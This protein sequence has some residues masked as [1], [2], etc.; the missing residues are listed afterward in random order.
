MNMPSLSPRSNLIV[1]VAGYYALAV[2][3]VVIVTLVLDQT[4]G[5]HHGTKKSIYKICFASAALVFLIAWDMAPVAKPDRKIMLV[6]LLW[7]Y[8]GWILFFVYYFVFYG[9]FGLGRTGSLVGD[10]LIVGLFGFAGFLWQSVSSPF[11]RH[12]ALGRCVDGQRMSRADSHVSFPFSSLE[13]NECE[14]HISPTTYYGFVSVAAVIVVIVA[15]A[16]VGEFLDTTF[17]APGYSGAIAAALVV[18][19]IMYPIHSRVSRFISF[20]MQ[21]DVKEARRN[22]RSDV[23]EVLSGFPRM[24]RL[25]LVNH[26]LASF[27]T[28]VLCSLFAWF[29]VLYLPSVFLAIGQ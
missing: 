24:L 10:L 22:M 18:A 26:P 25:F 9:F 27:L 14:I 23:A 7:I 4:L 17:P 1:Q 16:V 28:V 13:A 12:W 20:D 11:A 6:R 3:L 19:A 21:Q 8:A 15:D 29:T 2:G 5:L